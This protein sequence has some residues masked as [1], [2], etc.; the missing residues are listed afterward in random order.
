MATI[1]KEEN[2]LT[3]E[4]LAD[5]FWGAI[6]NN[7]ICTSVVQYMKPE[8]LPGRDFQALLEAIKSFY[9][10]FHHAPKYS[11]IRQEVD[12]NESVVEL[13][14]DIKET[15]TD[16]GAEE[17]LEQ[18]ETYLKLIMFKKHMRKVNQLYKEKKFNEAIIED[19]KGSEEVLSFTLKEDPFIDVAETFESRF[20]ANQEQQIDN[21]YKKAITSF[22]IT[23]LDE[24]NKG[25]NLRGQLTII[26][27]Q[28]GI[29][30]SH[31]ARWIGSQCS[32]VD[33]AD[34]L[35]IQLEGKASETTDAYSASL[36]GCRTSDY[37]TGEIDESTLAEYIDVVKASAGRLVVKSYPKFGK[38]ISTTDIHNTLQE[39]KKKY[40]K[41]PDILIIDSGDLIADSSGRNYSAKEERK[42]HI[43]AMQDLKDIAND[44]DIWVVC[45]YQANI[46]DPEKTEDENFVLTEFNSS[47]A[48]GIAFPATHLFTLNQSKKEQQEK[49]MRIN[50]A[51]S[52]FFARGPVFKI[53]TDYEHEK[54]YDAVRSMNLQT[55]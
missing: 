43:R 4:Y 14:E 18:F 23:P 27:A 3:E 39:Y 42:M 49:I 45:T 8:F 11:I 5:L 29:G 1:I 25:Q 33:G 15:A 28:T 13:L 55:V 40:G 2:V 38:M 22:H 17:L 9:H 53:A 52:R 36:V 50:V 34:V 16:T 20:R 24:R 44:L 51:K 41:T 37:A 26:L 48:K 30:K 21:Q 47:E 7:Q 35:Q 19:R 46:S 12:T 6:N 54:F 10:S 32:Y 31:A